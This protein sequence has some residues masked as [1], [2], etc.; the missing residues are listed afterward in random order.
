MAIRPEENHPIKAAGGDI[1]KAIA[2]SEARVT[3]Q[4]ADLRTE[5]RTGFAELRK[6]NAESEARTTRQISEAQARNTRWL[7]MI[8]GLMI[9]IITLIDR[10]LG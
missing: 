6:E 4:I 10:L 2:E 5:V 3:H 8:G 1:R 9:A 7:L